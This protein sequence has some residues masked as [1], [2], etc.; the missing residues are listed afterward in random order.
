[1]I[2]IIIRTLLNRLQL[3]FIV[4]S[5]SSCD[6]KCNNHIKLISSSSNSSVKTLRAPLEDLRI[7]YK[8]L[9]G[10]TV[11]TEGKVW[12]EFENVSICPEEN[13]NSLFE[14]SCFWLDFQ[15]DLNINDSIMRFASGKVFVIRGTIDTSNKGHLNSYLG[16]IKNIYYFEQK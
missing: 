16:T 6:I 11:E 13:R 2:S 7:I 9:Q 1:M 10:K 12:F 4:L 15:K 5:L 14:K 3:S 8:S